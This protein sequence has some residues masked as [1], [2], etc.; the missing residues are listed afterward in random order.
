[1]ILIPASRQ[2]FSASA[3]LGTTARAAGV[4]IA[5]PEATKSF[6]MSTT[7]MAVF[8]GSIPSI[9]ITYLLWSDDS[10]WHLTTKLSDRRAASVE[11]NVDNQIVHTGRTQGASAVRCS[12]SLG[13]AVMILIRDSFTSLLL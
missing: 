9:C 4:S 10:P 8:F 2:I 13:D 11:R 7:I 6:C 1:M 5:A 3:S 12:A